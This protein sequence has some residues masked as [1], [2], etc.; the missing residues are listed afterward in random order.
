MRQPR[1]A[2]L[3]QR[4]MRMLV[5][6]SPVCSTWRSCRRRTRGFV[7]RQAGCLFS[8]VVFLAEMVVVWCG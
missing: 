4:T 7:L 6:G 2:S 8:F 5:I 1:L 3:P